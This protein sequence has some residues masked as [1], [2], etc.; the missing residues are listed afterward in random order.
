MNKMRTDKFVLVDQ[1]GK[2]L[3]FASMSAHDMVKT[4]AQ[5]SLIFFPVQDL[6]VLIIFAIRIFLQLS[7]LNSSSF[8]A[9]DYL[10]LKRP[11]WRRIGK[12]TA[13]KEWLIQFCANALYRF[14]SWSSIPPP[15]VFAKNNAIQASTKLTP[16]WWIT[17]GLFAFSASEHSV[18]QRGGEISADEIAPNSW[19]ND[20][21]IRLLP[22]QFKLFF[23]DQP[24]IGSFAMH[25]IASPVDNLLL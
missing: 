21:D 23:C 3:H 5:I 24:H 18:S 4:T 19:M 12:R 6:P 8:W 22:M 25:F 10:Y 1:F 14:W 13:C 17:W 9:R 20:Y 11:T 2:V 15:S 16:F 7:D